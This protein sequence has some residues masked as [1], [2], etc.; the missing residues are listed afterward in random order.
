MH[1]DLCLCSASPRLA[2]DHAR[3]VLVQQ[4]RRSVR[5]ASGSSSGRR[6]TIG[7]DQANDHGTEDATGKTT[8]EIEAANDSSGYSSSQRS[9]RA[10][11][12][13]SITLRSRTTGPCCTTSRS[14]R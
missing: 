2:L 6:I 7:S 10:R 4:L 1:T 8:F 13:Q 11:A 14:P 12:G 9:C 5:L 3:G